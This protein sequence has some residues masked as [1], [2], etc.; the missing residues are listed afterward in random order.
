MCVPSHRPNRFSPGLEDFSLSSDDGSDEDSMVDDS[1][2]SESDDDEN[3]SSSPPDGA[4]DSM[5]E[6]KERK[7]EKLEAPTLNPDPN[8]A[9]PAAKPTLK[10]DREE[11][12]EKPE[13]CDFHL[14]L[15]TAH[16]SRFDVF[17]ISFGT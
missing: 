6:K 4:E 13:V 12:E 16:S 8:I 1:L 9:E 7:E 2:N 5:Q 10:R 11:I 3:E 15:L 17:R 14:C